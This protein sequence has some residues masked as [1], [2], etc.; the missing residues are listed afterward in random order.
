MKSIL[1]RWLRLCI[2]LFSLISFIFFS[3]GSAYAA[4]VFPP[5]TAKGSVGI[6]GEISTAAPTR[7]ATIAT[8]SNG[9][10]FTTIPVAVTGICPTGLLVKLFDNNVFVGSTYCQGGSYSISVDLFSG[11]NDLVA[12]V[13]DALDQP[14]PDSNTVTLNYTDAQFLTFGTHVQ[15]TS[16]YAE[17]GAQPNTELDWPVILSG[18][19]GPYAVSIDWGDGS[20]TTLVSQ[21]DVGTLPLSHTYANAGIYEVIVKAADKNG[22][23]A[24]LQ[25]VADS[26][27]AA[28]SNNKPTNSGS[29]VITKVVWWPAAVL[30][31]LFFAVYWIGRR[32]ELFALRKALEKTRD[33][34]EKDNQLK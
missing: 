8:P 28:Q 34:E 23:E 33:Q 7:G 13:Y 10:T 17:R 9:A 26:T 4:S 32:A 29:T 16:N 19:T 21:A 15:L 27:G 20:P 14:G 12:I 25:L 22:G 11:Q 18:G 2:T 3:A 6:Q 5:E 1:V 31:P 30:L 24:F